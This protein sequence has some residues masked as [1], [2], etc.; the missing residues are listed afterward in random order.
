MSLKKL[1]AHDKKSSDS[2][3]VERGVIEFQRLANAAERIT[4]ALEKSADRLDAL[5][6]YLRAGGYA[7]SGK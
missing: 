5:I 7:R 1:R 6:A 2:D 3:L 4:V